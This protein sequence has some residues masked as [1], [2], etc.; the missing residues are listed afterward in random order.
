M[1]HIRNEIDEAIERN[2]TVKLQEIKSRLNRDQ[3]AWNEQKAEATKF[4]EAGQEI[5]IPETD[6]YQLLVDLT[7]VIDNSLAETNEALLYLEH[8]E[9]RRAKRLLREEV[10]SLPT[11]APSVMREEFINHAISD[12][13]EEFL[14]EIVKDL[15]EKQTEIMD[16]VNAAMETVRMFPTVAQITFDEIFDR[17]E[18]II[19]GLQ[20]D[21]TFIWMHLQRDKE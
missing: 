20:N 8:C 6:N 21:I 11:I 13:S 19:D 16:Y 7:R 4:W 15:S 5:I 3:A 18:D 12:G 14:R 17:A 1:L 9:A 10:N 2:D